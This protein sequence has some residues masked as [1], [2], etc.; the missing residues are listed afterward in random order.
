MWSWSTRNCI[1]IPI[2]L[3][4]PKFW[5]NAM[6][7]Q[8]LDFETLVAS[9]K[10]HI[11]SISEITRAIRALVEEGYPD[12][13]VCGEVSNFRDPGSGHFYFTLKDADSQ[14]SAVMFRGANAKLPFQIKDGLE[15]VCHGK[16][17]VYEARGNYQIVLDYCEPKGVG[18]L[19]LAFEQLKKKLSEERLFD[20]KYKKKIPFLPE[21]IG[22]VTS[23]TGALLRT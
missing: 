14:L 2:R 18:A 5:K 8:V 21:K 1:G 15:M 11:H 16:L 13:W 7:Q 22:V 4:P 10:P 3:P 6:E 12:V 20:R 19:Q 17:T 9:K 23:G